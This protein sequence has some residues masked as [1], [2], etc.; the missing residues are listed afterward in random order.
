MTD[1]LLV[2][3]YS[4]K[5][6]PLSLFCFQRDVAVGCID[7]FFD[8]QKLFQ[9]TGPMLQHTKVA[10]SETKKK[11]VENGPGLVL[12]DEIYVKD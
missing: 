7:I 11:N 10:T 8:S 5:K 4:F 9:S 2:R 3:Y 12:K 6:R 1:K